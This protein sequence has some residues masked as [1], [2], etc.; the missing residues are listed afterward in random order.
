MNYDAFLGE[1]QHRLELPDEGHAAKMT[2]VVLNTLGERLGEGEAA[3]LAAPLPME[4]DRFLTESRGGQQ[5]TYQ[6]FIDRVCRRADVEEADAHFYAQAIV[7]LVA[8]C[9]TGSEMQQ[10]QEQLPEDYEELFEFT[11]QEAVPW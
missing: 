5:F 8:E 4:I 2:R 9:A 11:E 10:V 3:D 6:E 7:A 1:V